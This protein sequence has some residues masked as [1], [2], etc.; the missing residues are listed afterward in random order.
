MKLDWYSIHSSVLWED[1][2]NIMHNERYG[3]NCLK[4]SYQRIHWNLNLYC[5]NKIAFSENT[6]K[7]SG[8]EHW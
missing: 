6:K 5:I 4:C 8:L 3:N 2:Q 1:S 7:K